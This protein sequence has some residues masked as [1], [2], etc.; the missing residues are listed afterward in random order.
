MTATVKGGAMRVKLS[1]GRTITVDEVRLFGCADMQT[2]TIDTRQR[3]RE[4]MDTFIHE[5]MHVANPRLSEKTVH[6]MA[7][8]ITAVLWAAGYRRNKTPKG[9]AR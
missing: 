2:I 4:L 6:Q 5:A 1:N 8:D 7:N 9:K 3:G